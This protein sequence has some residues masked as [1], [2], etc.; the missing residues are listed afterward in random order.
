MIRF[1]MKDTF[2]ELF[3][4]GRGFCFMSAL[5]KYLYYMNM[6]NIFN[7]IL[8]L[9]YKLDFSDAFCNQTFNALARSIRLHTTAE[10]GAEDFAIFWQNTD[11]SEHKWTV[12]KYIM[13]H[14][15]YFLGAF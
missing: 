14:E 4:V 13:L 12:E 10:T 9:V 2:R 8:D 7:K 3:S 5:H 6:N 11:C 15:L 1:W